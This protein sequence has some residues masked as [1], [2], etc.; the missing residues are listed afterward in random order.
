[1]KSSSTLVDKSSSIKAADMQTALL[2]LAEGLLV[3]GV[4]RCRGWYSLPSLILVTVA[5]AVLL[6]LFLRR[7]F[8][9]FDS[10]VVPGTGLLCVGMLLTDLV[11]VD[12][13][14]FGHSPQIIFLKALPFLA[15]GL[16]GAGWWTGRDRLGRLALAA[17]VLGFALYLAAQLLRTPS[18]VMDVWTITTEAAEAFLAGKN[19][20]R[21]FYTDVYEKAG[22]PGY[23][24]EMRFIYLPGHLLHAALP[25]AFG[26]DI[27]WVSLVAIAGG[28]GLF[29]WI[30]E[31]NSS[32]M[33]RVGAGTAVIIFWVHGGQPYLLEQ[34]WPEAMLLVYLCL[35]LWAWSSRPRIACIALVLALSLK[36]TTWFFAPFLIALLVAERR[37]GV[38]A[39]VAGGVALIVSPFFFWDPHAFFENVVLDLLQKSPRPNALSWASV[40]LRR[41][42]S[43][44]ALITALSYVVYFAALAMLINRLRKRPREEWL[45]ETEKWMI[46]GVFGFFL[47]LKQAF[48]NYY[49][50][51]SGLL[52]FYLIR[53]ALG[54]DGAA[55][56]Q[57]QGSAAAKPNLSDEESHTG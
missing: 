10:L 48:F 30:V 54:G 38:I 19:P 49:Y 5:F 8:E 40:V 37:W 31:C 53:E 42:P 34:S 24:Y 29:A 20:Y 25:A 12:P 33:L 1:M 32:R 4:W 9:G 39:V 57:L 16:L 35:A 51:V 15:V 11:V 17:G 52:A 7:H 46:V 43:A 28:L 50:L 36:Q 14:L 23:G 45:A 47:F 26:L 6:F 55:D 13:L 41:V 22:M 2:L 56:P 21:L 18:P 3:F 27:R 44:F